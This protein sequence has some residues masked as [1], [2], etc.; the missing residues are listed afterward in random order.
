MAPRR[1]RDRDDAVAD[2]IEAVAAALRDGEATVY[3]YRVRDDPDPH[4]TGA[5]AY[6]GGWF[7]FRIE[8][9]DAS[10]GGAAR[11]SA[12]A[13]TA[14]GDESTDA[15]DAAALDGD[16]SGTGNGAQE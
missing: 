7:E 13:P 2:A 4:R 10:G 15:G 1:D 6:P 12:D 3:G 14:D 8:P 5:V 11:G 9:D 16:G